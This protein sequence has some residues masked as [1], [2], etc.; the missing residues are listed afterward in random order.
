MNIKI[1]EI[2]SGKG[3][4]VWAVTP[5]STVYEAIEMMASKGVG[6]LAVKSGDR[7]AGILSE[8]D[9]ARKVILKGKSS[10]ETMVK[11]IMTTNVVCVSEERKVDE[12]LA[13][14]TEKRI[15][16]L[17]VVE[18]DKLLGMIS[19]GDLVK[20]TIK[21]QSFTIEQLESYIRGG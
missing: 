3:S 16:H 12:C 17:P 10:R 11:D 7:L 2:L 20:A 15:R 4:E 5:D 1:K 9:Y 14:M 18:G 8:R 6:A 19:V 13:L 21:E